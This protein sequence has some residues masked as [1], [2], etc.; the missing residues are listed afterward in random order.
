MQRYTLLH[1]GSNLG[2]QAAYLAFHLSA[3]LGAP[4]L[5]LLD[6]PA[7]DSAMIAQRATQVEV[8][9]RAAG[10]VIRT[11]LVTDFTVDT[12]AEYAAGNNG[13]IVPRHLIQE[14]K[15]PL[16]FLETLSCPLWVVT[17]ES[18]MRNLATLVNNPATDKHLVDYS[19]SLAQRLQESLVGLASQ[20]NIDSLSQIYTTLPWHQLPDFSPAKIAEVLD[21]LDIDILFLP[22]SHL[23]LATELPISC[24]IHPA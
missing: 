15:V 12:V 1:D 5:V 20:S 11:R 4:L 22:F 19:A 17:M 13:L 6:E 18:E 14:E 2:W 8:G 24:V 3:R 7:I 21:R 10:L 23:S 9:G 16:L